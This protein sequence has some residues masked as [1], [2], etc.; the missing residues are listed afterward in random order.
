SD[1]SVNSISGNNIILL[2]YA[3]VLLMRAEALLESDS[4]SAH[5]SEIIKLV[6]D[7]RQRPSVGMPKIE[8]AEG[9]TVGRDDLRDI[10][11]HE[12]RVE[13]AFEGTRISDIKRWEIGAIAYA[14]G[15]GYRPEL[16]G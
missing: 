15:I 16:L 9:S 1:G 12:R 3:D 7:V 11:R 5:R 6:N 2:R 4:W 8:D 13:F 14:D 10:I